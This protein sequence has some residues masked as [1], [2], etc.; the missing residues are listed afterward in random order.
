MQGGACDREKKMI[1][2]I[3]KRRDGKMRKE[4]EGNSEWIQFEFYEAI[5]EA[6]I[7]FPLRSFGPVSS[8]FQKR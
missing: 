7:K 8:N 4:T 2:V 6:L 1:V 5:L 3:Q